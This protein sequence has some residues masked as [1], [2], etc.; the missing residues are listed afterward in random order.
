MSLFLATANIAVK[1]KENAT[2]PPFK[3]HKTYE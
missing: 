2:L 1:N 3:K